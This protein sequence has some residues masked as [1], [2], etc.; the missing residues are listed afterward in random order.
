VVSVFGVKFS[1][2]PLNEHGGAGGAGGEDE[3]LVF[4]DETG[5]S[6]DEASDTSVC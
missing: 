5:D 6:V 2:D 4:G 3:E 1:L